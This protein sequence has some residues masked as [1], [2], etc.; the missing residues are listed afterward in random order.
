M[1]GLTRDGTAEP[2]P[3]DEIL[4]RTRRQGKMI[5]L[6]QLTTSRIGSVT[7]LIYFNLLKVMTIHTIIY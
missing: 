4:R 5:L 6:F 3:R 2:V 7:R 1:S